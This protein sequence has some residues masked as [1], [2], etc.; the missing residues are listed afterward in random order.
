MNKSGA[1]TS[2]LLGLLAGIAFLGAVALLM[3]NEQKTERPEKLYTTSGG[4]VDM[5][6]ACHKEEKLDPAHDPA[7]IGCSSCHLGNSLAVAKE[8]AHRDM[9]LN[10]GDL[11]VA[12][13]TC[14]ADGCHPRDIHKVKNS[15]MATNRGILGTLL[16]YWGESDSQNTDLTVEQLL[17][18]EENSLALDYFRKLCAT[19]HLWKQ[20]NDLENAPEFFNSKGGGCSACHYHLPDAD[21]M[22]GI[23]V[24]DGTASG[25][26]PTENRKKHPWITKKVESANCVRC[27]N[28]S[29]RIGLSYLGIFESEGYGTPYEEGGLN[30]KQLP[31]ARFYLEIS[32]DIHHQK[33]MECID[34]HTRD[35]IMGNG[36]S[37][38]HYEEQ[39]EI[40]C[41][42]CH[43]KNPGTTRKG[44]VLTNLDR[45]DGKPVLTGKL[46]NKTHPLNPP[47]S[48]ICDFPPHSRVSCEA[49]HST[50]VAQCYG[51][52]AKRDDSGKHLDKLSLEQTKGLW[53]EGRSYIRYERPMLG[54]WED[55]VVV[56]TPGCQDIVTV[57]DDQGNIEN[58]FNRFTMAA[59]NP[60]TTQPK[61]RSCVD[62]HAST[63]T[64]GLG[65]GRIRVVDGKMIFESTEQGVVTSG[66]ATVPFDAYVTMDGDPL[67]H[68]SR[69]ALRPFNKKELEA[70]LRVGL[71]VGCHDSYEDPIWKNYSEKSRCVRQEG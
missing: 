37:Y 41:T 50:W 26:I 49:C 15:L 16:Y 2:T 67:Q 36:T 4:T 24:G 5:C 18:S 12:E 23:I 17:D 11:R 33:Q 69:S 1:I 32:D 42:V 70:I 62:C 61:G 8:E 10:P 66:G 65:E 6:L 21:S 29:G 7:V 47:K 25:V 43:A 31:G 38:A 45:I 19:C 40:S 55:E 14:A 51:C 13:K 57:I 34:C 22:A 58:S 44:N 20:K 54:I 56:V 30:S 52:H 63:K 59:I 68:S 71:C 3:V 60:H 48:G 53:E 64:V 27:H 39:L 46:D 9:V 35:E 28:R